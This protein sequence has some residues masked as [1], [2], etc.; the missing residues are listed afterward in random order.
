MNADIAF[1]NPNI[2]FTVRKGTLP[3]GERSWALVR[4]YKVQ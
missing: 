3:C 4:E 1:A 2:R